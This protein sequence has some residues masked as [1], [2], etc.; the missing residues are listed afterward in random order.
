MLEG[1]EYVCQDTRPE[2]RRDSIAI[3]AAKLR[4]EQDSIVEY[5]K[6]LEAAKTWKAP[7]GKTV[8]SKVV[9][10]ANVVIAGH[11]W[12]DATQDDSEV[13]GFRTRYFATVKNDIGVLMTFSVRKDK[14]DQMLPDF[15]AMMKTLQVRRRGPDDTDVGA[16]PAPSVTAIPST[17]AT[18]IASESS[19]GVVAFGDSAPKN[20]PKLRACGCELP[21]GSE[22]SPGAVLALL[23]GAVLWRRRACATST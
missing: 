3:F 8:V 2:L 18:P 19:N 20:A 12:V 17:S 22:N 1:A 16:G 13:V 4:G 6:H 10:V 7:D 23:F 11:P 15:D 21:G 14:Y 5:R 9:K